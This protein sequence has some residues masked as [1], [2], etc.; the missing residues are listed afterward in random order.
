[1]HS[2]GSGTCMV[3]SVTHDATD[4]AYRV[5]ID[6]EYAAEVRFRWSTGFSLS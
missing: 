6:P 1:M 3:F 4:A 2:Q 5:T